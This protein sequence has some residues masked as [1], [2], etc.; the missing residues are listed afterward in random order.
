MQSGMS[1]P[2]GS[3]GPALRLLTE[4]SLKLSRPLTLILSP[5]SAMSAPR[6]QGPGTGLA[7]EKSSVHVC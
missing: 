6:E 7:H 5:A 2:P 4:P 3:R 1:S